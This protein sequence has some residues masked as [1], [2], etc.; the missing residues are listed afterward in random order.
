MKVL[1]II[2]G[3]LLIL[4]AAGVEGGG[5]TCLQGLALGMAGGTLMIATM[6]Q[7]GWYYE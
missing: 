2:G 1:H 3:L 5:F 7:T 4:A 6:K